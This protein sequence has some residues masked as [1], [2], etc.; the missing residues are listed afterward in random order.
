MTQRC[1]R[2]SSKVGRTAQLSRPMHWWVKSLIDATAWRVVLKL[3]ISRPSASIVRMHSLMHATAVNWLS[4]KL[5]QA[6]DQYPSSL[7]EVVPVH[8][9]PKIIIFLVRHLHGASGRL[10]YGLLALVVK[11]ARQL[12]VELPEMQT[13]VCE[14]TCPQV[15]PSRGVGHHCG[16][17]DDLLKSIYRKSAT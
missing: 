17:Y 7:H 16:C 2:W 15:F 14:P 11:D 9:S 13:S 4:V 8:R 6:L 3:Y 5:E 1:S 10:G 12:I